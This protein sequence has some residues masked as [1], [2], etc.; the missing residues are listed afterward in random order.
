MAI[1]LHF[2]NPN[3]PGVKLEIFRDTTP[4]DRANLPAPIATL[5]THVTKWTDETAIKGLTYYYVFKTT[6]TMDSKITRNIKIV[7]QDDK[8]VGNDKLVSGNLDYGYYGNVPVSSFFSP[9]QLA[10]AL[11][12]TFL[13]YGAPTLWHKFS[14]K[15]KTV[16]VPNSFIGKGGNSYDS[17]VAKGLINGVEVQFGQF[18]YRVRLMKGFDPDTQL[19]DVFPNSTAT[20]DVINLPDFTCEY[21]RFIYP[22]ARYIPRTQI[23]HNLDAR[24]IAE[25]GYPGSFMMAE[26][27]SATVNLVRGSGTDSVSGLSHAGLMSRTSAAADVAFLPVLELVTDEL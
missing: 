15:G 8:G 16:F 1:T 10:S 4:I 7:A 18:K 17:L 6:G 14:D 26:T 19:T 25:L 20:L 22:M 3:P 21:D 23:I 2:D 9:Q 11:G 27:Y 24:S 12:L 5:L 13:S